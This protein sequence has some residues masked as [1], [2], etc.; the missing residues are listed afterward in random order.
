LRDAF[1]AA[2]R[3]SSATFACRR[4]RIDGAHLTR[5]PER[6]PLLLSALP[7]LDEPALCATGKGPQAEARQFGIPPEELAC[8]D[9]AACNIAVEPDTRTSLGDGFQSRMLIR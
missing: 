3:P 2:G 8:P 9:G 7:E 5:T 6:D 1:G 4:A